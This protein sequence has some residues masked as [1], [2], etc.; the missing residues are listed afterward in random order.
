MPLPSSYELAINSNTFNTAIAIC[1][2]LTNK[3]I[4][5]NTISNM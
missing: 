1:F 4:F 2:D 3:V 5:T